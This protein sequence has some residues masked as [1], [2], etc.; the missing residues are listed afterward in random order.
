MQYSCRWQKHMMAGGKNVMIN[1]WWQKDENDIINFNIPKV[2]ST[3][4]IIR[5][6][7]KFFLITYTDISTESLPYRVHI[8][9]SH[10]VSDLDLSMLYKYSFLII[11]ICIQKKLQDPW[12]WDV[13]WECF[14]GIHPASVLQSTKVPVKTTPLPYNGI[15]RLLFNF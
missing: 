3:I 11:C 4:H 9:A 15:S 2:N 13:I 14:H 12:N 10:E 8:K 6:L 1:P 7:W 5:D